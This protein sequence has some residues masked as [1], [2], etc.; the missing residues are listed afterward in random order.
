MVD[1]WRLS[2][3]DREAM[4]GQILLKVD[5]SFQNQ[6]WWYRFTFTQEVTDAFFYQAD[7]DQVRIYS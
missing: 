7:Q 4:H 1:H 5:P 3:T 6:V 2:E